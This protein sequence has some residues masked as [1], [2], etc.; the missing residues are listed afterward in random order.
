MEDNFLRASESCKG[1][2]RTKHLNR[3]KSKWDAGEIVDPML[4]IGS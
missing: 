1:R 3:L 4:I 2:S